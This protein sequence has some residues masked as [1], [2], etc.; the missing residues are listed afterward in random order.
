[1]CRDFWQQWR[2]RGRRRSSQGR[3][4]YTL[5]PKVQRGDERCEHLTSASDPHS[6]IRIRRRHRTPCNRVH[7]YR[8]IGVYRQSIEPRALEPLICYTRKCWKC[9]V[10]LVQTVSI[11]AFVI[12]VIFVI[13]RA[14]NLLPQQLYTL[15]V[16]STCAILVVSLGYQGWW[17]P[18]Q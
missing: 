1:M 3:V 12:F 2:W 10:E 7:I 16:N 15:V 17:C 14:R 11:V 18:V 5:Q 6:T 9:V 4:C 8:T 13:Y